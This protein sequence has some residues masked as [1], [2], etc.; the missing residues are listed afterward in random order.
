MFL[1]LVRSEIRFPNIFV[2]KTGIQGLL[3]LMQ[4]GLLLRMLSIPL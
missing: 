2:A 3:P 1:T 4:L